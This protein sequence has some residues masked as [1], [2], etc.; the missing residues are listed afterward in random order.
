MTNPQNPSLL[1]VSDANRAVRLFFRQF[2]DENPAL[3]FEWANVPWAA[4]T[5]FYVG[6]KGTKFTLSK[7][8]TLAEMT[9]SFGHACSEAVE[10]LIRA[11][12]EI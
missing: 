12:Y 1:G 9:D 3:V 10:Y 11:I 4:E 6:L 7:T 8:L 2:E 5:R